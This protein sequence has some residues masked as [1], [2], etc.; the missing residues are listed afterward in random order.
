MLVMLLSSEVTLYPL[1][2]YL[3]YILYDLIIDF[4]DLLMHIERIIATVFKVYFINN[5]K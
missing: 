2:N 1:T 5:K 3:I 4:I